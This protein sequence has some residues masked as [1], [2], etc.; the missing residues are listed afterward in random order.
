[1]F[2]ARQAATAEFERALTEQN[3]TLEQ[4]R[5]FVKKHPR[6]GSALHRAPH[7]YAGVGADLV[8][9]VA[10][11]INKTR[12]QRLAD[13]VLGFT[14]KSRDVAQASPHMVVS[15]VKTTVENAPAIAAKLREDVEMIKEQRVIAK[16]KKRAAKTS[17][18]QPS[19]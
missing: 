12:T 8:A 19:A 10:P 17:D 15:F 9:E 13:A 16:K 6:F 1:M 2:K 7:A 4:V 18:I 14:K 5:E 3:V 11:Y